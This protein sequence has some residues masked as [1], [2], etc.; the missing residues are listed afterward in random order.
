MEFEK[1]LFQYQ[2]YIAIAERMH[3]H[4]VPAREPVMAGSMDALPMPN[5]PEPERVKKGIWRPMD[6][7]KAAARLREARN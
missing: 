5:P 7:Q 2:K 1:I 4:E 3:L 6:V